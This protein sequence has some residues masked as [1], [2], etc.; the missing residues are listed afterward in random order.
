MLT[1]MPVGHEYLQGHDGSVGYLGSG[2]VP[3]NVLPNTSG[4]AYEKDGQF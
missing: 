4:V 3:Y 1:Y 2:N